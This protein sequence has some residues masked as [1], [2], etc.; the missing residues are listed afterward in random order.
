MQLSPIER[1]NGAEKLRCN[2]AASRNKKGAGPLAGDPTPKL[3]QISNRFAAS[4]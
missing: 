2:A 4:G 3:T 1:K